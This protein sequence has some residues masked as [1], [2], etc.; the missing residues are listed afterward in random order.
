MPAEVLWILTVALFAGGLAAVALRGR[1]RDRADLRELAV[2]CRGAAKDL[3]SLGDGVVAW[4]V[5]E[6]QIEITA[7]FAAFVLMYTH[8]EGPI[9]DRKDAYRRG[10]ATTLVWHGHD[11]EQAP[12]GKLHNILHKEG[13]AEEDDRGD[14]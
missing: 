10:I 3:P 13:F 8:H 4:P 12:T 5:A 14:P 6:K 1:A 9:T 2:R 7:E 11:P